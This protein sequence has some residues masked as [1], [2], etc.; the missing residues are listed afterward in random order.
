[1]N[2]A[3]SAAD[4]VFID[5]DLLRQLCIRLFVDAGAS[6]VHAER[7]V[8]HLVEASAM[9]L[10]SH[11]LIRVPQYLAE[12][13]AGELDP[14]AVAEVTWRQGGVAH[15]DGNRA[16][17]AVAGA[18]LVDL[19]ADLARVH[20]LGLVSGRRLGH[21]GR[22]GAF[23]E[24]LALRGLIGVVVCS[25]P[26]SGH[27]VAP[28][29]GRDGR[30]ATN[31]IAFAFPV[32]S[33]P[34]VVG[35]F[36][37]AATAEGVIRSLR[38]REMRAPMGFLRDSSGRLTDDPS[39]LYSPSPGAIQP[40]GG[41]FGYRGTA[42]AILVEALATLLAGDAPT[43]MSRVGTNMAVLAIAPQPGFERLAKAL[44]EHIRSSRPIESDRPVMM[45]GDRERRIAAAADAIAVDP[46]TLEAIRAAADTAGIDFE[47][48]RRQP[49]EERD[50]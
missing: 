3:N 11:G 2:R 36:S 42:L 34:P 4:A 33:S 26:P 27:W 38:N 12:I 15:V 20:G 39:V 22:V 10:A 47:W 7:V 41:D 6:V 24:A 45:P 19:A 8:D 25:G 30:L 1:M 48:P 50:G 16:F 18:F 32:E 14:V 40:F 17:G 31:P 44:A 28:F 35:D 9:G 23:P 37:T 5:R 21:T 49:H 43:D 29:G 13:A 46:P